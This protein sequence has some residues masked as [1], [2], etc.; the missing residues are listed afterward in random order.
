MHLPRFSH[1]LLQVAILVLLI[2]GTGAGIAHGAPSA[3][4]QV[5]DGNLVFTN[6][7]QNGLRD[8]HTS[9]N[10]SGLR[11]YNADTLTVNPQGAAIQF[12]GN[13]S[14]FTGQAF[15]D[16]GAH[17]NAAVIF[18]TAGTGQGITERMRIAANGNVGIG[19]SAPSSLLHAADGTARFELGP[20]QKMSLGGEGS[21]EIDAFGM[22]AGRFLVT[23]GGNVGIGT[24]TPEATLEVNGT[25]RIWGSTQLLDS[26]EIYG[27]LVP[28]VDSV[29]DLGSA[30][31]RWNEIF[32]AN[33]T[34]NTSDGRLKDQIDALPY[35]L[36]EIMHLRPITFTWKDRAD[37]TVHLGLVAQEVEAVIPEAIARSGDPTAPLGLNYANLIPVLI[38]A[39][40]EQQQALGQRDAG[41]A[42]QQERITALEQRNETLEARLAAL[43]RLLGTGQP[44]VQAQR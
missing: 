42:A 32:V 7:G 27:S 44:L 29:Y 39:I 24:A 35:G 36:A 13:G 5:V 8:I 33:G 18:R 37:G 41:I 43:E 16:S 3:A 9:G 4:D 12:W 19:T 23:D 14:A 15:V 34:F 28:G 2:S 1:R 25:T 11:F 17:N 20:G 10:Q 26:A 40:Q 38:Q 6:P 30:Q 22:P 21:F 31:Y